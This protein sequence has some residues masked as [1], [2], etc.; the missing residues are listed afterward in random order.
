MP[1]TH[2]QVYS[3]AE[4]TCLLVDAALSEARKD[5]RVLEVGSGTGCISE[6]L[7]STGRFVLATDINPHAVRETAGKGVN[8]VRADL[9]AGIKGPFD[10]VVFNPPY[11]PTQ[12]EERMDDWL[13]YAL[14]GG[15]D[16]CMVIS[17]FAEQLSRVLA[18]GGRAL[19]L[20]SSLTGPDMV[21]RIFSFHG[22]RTDILTDRRIEGEM[23]YV[24]RVQ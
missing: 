15:E 13:E 16:G 21:L 24:M 14:N 1:V 20:F 18:P 17:R 12:P 11:L 2:P 22:F 4:D 6:R 5:D 23:L 7:L 10:L 19:L 8:V 9:L 3:P